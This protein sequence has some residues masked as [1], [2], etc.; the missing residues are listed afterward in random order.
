MG[1]A[2]TASAARAMVSGALGSASSISATASTICSR[3]NRAGR[4]RR[5]AGEGC[6]L[7]ILI[8]SMAY[9]YPEANNWGRFRGDAHGTSTRRARGARDWREPEHREGHGGR[10]GR[11]RRHHLRHGANVEAEA[12]RARQPRADRRRDRGTRWQ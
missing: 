7:A 10:G 4:P 8:L 1:L 11:R 9:A 3:E 12:R 6:A 5:G 2:P